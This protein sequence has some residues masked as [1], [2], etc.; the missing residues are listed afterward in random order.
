MLV[1]DLHERVVDHEGDGHVET[2]AAQAGDRALVEPAAGGTAS[3]THTTHGPQ[4]SGVIRFH[5]Q[6]YLLYIYYCITMSSSEERC[7]CKEKI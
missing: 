5:Y 3:N 6:I 2:H 4:R 1:E 7:L